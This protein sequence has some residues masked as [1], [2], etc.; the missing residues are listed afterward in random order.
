MVVGDR[1][2][3]LKKSGLFSLENSNSLLGQV[4]ALQGVG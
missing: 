1:T 3:K 4:A 2:K